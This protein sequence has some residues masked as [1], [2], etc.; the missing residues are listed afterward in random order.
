MRGHVKSYDENNQELMANSVDPKHLLWRYTANPADILTARMNSRR[1]AVLACDYNS[2][3][4]FIST[5]S[6]VYAKMGNLMASNN[7]AGFVILYR[8]DLVFTQST[9]NC[10]KDTEYG[11]PCNASAIGR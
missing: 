2:L 3:I 5:L 11:Y 6:K 8:K 7:S 4:G 9:R 10:M 1:T